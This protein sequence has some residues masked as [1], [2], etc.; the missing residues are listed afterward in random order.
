MGLVNARVYRRSPITRWS[1]IFLNA[2]KIRLSE[3]HS[4]TQ[5]G[6][7]VVRVSVFIVYLYYLYC[8]YEM[9]R[10]DTLAFAVSG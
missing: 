1:L 7:P 6:A 10:T 4:F 8:I 3:Q 5:Y 9:R 2:V